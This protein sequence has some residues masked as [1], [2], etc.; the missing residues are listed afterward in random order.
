MS[1][2]RNLN[3]KRR[4]T[5]ILWKRYEK[6]II[7]NK[8][9]LLGKKI[10]DLLPNRSLHSIITKASQLG[11]SYKKR[12]ISYCIDCGKKCCYQSIS[13]LCRSCSAKR[14]YKKR[15][16]FTH[17]HGKLWNEQNLNILKEKY[18]NS[19]KEELCKLLNRNWSCITHKAVRLKIKR[20]P[21]FMRVN[22]FT[23]YKNPML[24]DIY[25]QK[26]IN[27]HRENW[28][29]GKVKLSGIALKSSLGLTKKENH[30]NWLGGISFE[31]YDKNWDKKFK[32]SILKRDGCC[33]ICNISIEDLRLIK[34]QICVHHINYDKKLSIKENCLVLCNSCH[35][36]TNFNRVH[37]TK[38]F[39][40]LLS[41]RYYYKYNDGEIILE[42]EYNKD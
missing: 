10:Q 38:F 32:S 22:N 27:K 24:N 14:N 6:N 39:Q 19:S 40:S 25:K 7:I 16:I 2:A 8:Y 15:G 3:L 4:V 30:P 12:K 17:H 41:E 28:N 26:A 21:K 34:K 18:Y 31:P 35:M 13:Y 20:N 1:R 36:K 11:I 37:W 5:P 33:M 42:Y 23:S 29:N 9:N